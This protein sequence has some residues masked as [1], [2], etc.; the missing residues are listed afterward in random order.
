MLLLDDSLFNVI[1][2]DIVIDRQAQCEQIYG[3]VGD[4][5]A[6]FFIVCPLGV[7]SLFRPIIESYA[8]MVA[9]LCG[10]ILC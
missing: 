2:L 7:A 6:D 1:L 8:E 4:A 5:F 9:Q 10:L 3:G